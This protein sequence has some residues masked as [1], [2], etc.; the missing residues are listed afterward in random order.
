MGN[1]LEKH[2]EN[3]GWRFVGMKKENTVLNGITVT[4]TRIE[5]DF[6]SSIPNYGWHVFGLPNNVSVKQQTIKCVKRESNDDVYWL[7]SDAKDIGFLELIKHAQMI[8]DVNTSIEEKRNL[9]ALKIE[10][11]TKLFSELE[12][13]ELKS[14]TFKYKAKKKKNVKVE[15]VVAEP[16]NNSSNSE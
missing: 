16:Q 3:I 6:K 13:N 4:L 7:F 15:E 11:L 9:L 14:L 12:Y 2:I 8:I 1:S 10:E 5:I